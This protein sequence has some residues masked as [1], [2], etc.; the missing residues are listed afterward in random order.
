MG[1]SIM[2]ITEENIREDENDKDY[3]NLSH[4]ETKLP[5]IDDMSEYEIG[6]KIFK[7]LSLKEVHQVLDFVERIKNGKREQ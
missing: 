6:S 5:D 1:E 2:K 3:I 4:Y 7:G